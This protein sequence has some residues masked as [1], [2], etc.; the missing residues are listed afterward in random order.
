M[1]HNIADGIVI[2]AAF[3]YCSKSFGW[4]LT[5]ATIAHECSQELADWFILTGAG[6]LTNM[7]AIL[8]NVISSASAIVG[9]M[10]IVIMEDEA[11]STFVGICLSYGGGMYLF[12]A[13]AE[14]APLMFKQDDKTVDIWKQLIGFCVG[15]MALGLVLLNHEHCSVGGDTGGDAHAGHGH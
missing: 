10:I 13:L 5:G 9:A 11:H 4:T 2:G 6:R 8:L 12:I 14:I 15:V 3:L 1:F 7:Q